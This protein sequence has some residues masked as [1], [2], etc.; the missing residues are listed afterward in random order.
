M[1]QQGRIRTDPMRIPYLDDFAT[2][3]PVLDRPMTEAEMKG[4]T[5]ALVEGENK[6]TKGQSRAREI[7]K[8]KRRRQIHICFDFASK[9]A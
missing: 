6:S 9:P 7:R 3:R 5:Q 4:E 8:R 1:A 2:M